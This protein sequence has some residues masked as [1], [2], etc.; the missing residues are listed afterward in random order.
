[1]HKFILNFVKTQQDP[2]IRGRLRI[3]GP[4]SIKL[5]QIVIYLTISRLEFFEDLISYRV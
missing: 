2:E 3:Y 1:M 5:W 4:P